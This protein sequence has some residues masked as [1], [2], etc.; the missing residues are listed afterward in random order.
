MPTL[1][2]V[3]ALPTTPTLPAVA[4]LPATATLPAVATLPAT[5]TLPAVATLPATATLLATAPLPATATLPSTATLPTTA[6][7][8]SGSALVA[9][10]PGRVPSLRV[11]SPLRRRFDASTNAIRARGDDFSCIGGVSRKRRHLVVV[12]QA[13]RLSQGALLSHGRGVG[14]CGFVAGSG[15]FGEK[16]PLPA[17]PHAATVLP[18][19][20]PTVT[21]RTGSV[22]CST[23]ALT[24]GFGESNDQGVGVA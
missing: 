3:A 6:T 13:G 18:R 15:N 4:A 8:C 2:T 24:E 19:T 20:S 23:R 12:S 5:A 11:A 9:N 14:I 22:P 17:R 16:L 7:G 21:S 10:R 1:R